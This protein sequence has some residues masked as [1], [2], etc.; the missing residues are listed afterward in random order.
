MRDIRGDLRERIDLLAAERVKLE[1]RMTELSKQEQSYKLALLQEEERFNSS[2]SSS[3]SIAE[4]AVGSSAGLAELLITAIAS[5]N[6]PVDLDELKTEI[7]KTPYDFGDRAPGRAIHFGL[8]GLANRG[9]VEKLPDGRWAMRHT[10]GI[11]VRERT[12]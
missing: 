4:A 7:G 10:N 12:Q 8:V 5:K 3:H 1:T 6:R 9:E 11:P 2:L